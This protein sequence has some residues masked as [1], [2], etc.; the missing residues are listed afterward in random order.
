MVMRAMGDEGLAAEVAR[1]RQAG[2]AGYPGEDELRFYAKVLNGQIEI[3]DP[4]GYLRRRGSAG[5]DD[6]I[7]EDMLA[8]WADTIGGRVEKLPS[9]ADSATLLPMI[10]LGDKALPRL[11][12]V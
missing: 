5:P 2:A 12:R 8:M 10:V 11:Y 7:D 6:V 9:T 1:L 4:V 3:D